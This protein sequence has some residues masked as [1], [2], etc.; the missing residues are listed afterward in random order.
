M[1]ERLGRFAI[2]YRLMIIT[3]WVALAAIITIVAPNIDDVASSDQT[4]FLPSNA[5]FIQANEVFQEAFPDEFARGS[6]FVVI[7]ASKAGGVNDPQVWQFIGELEAWLNSDAAPDNI[8]GVKAPTTNSL[9]PRL[10]VSEDQQLALVSIDLNTGHIDPLTGGT[11][12]AIDKWVGEHKLE[13]VVVEQTGASPVV[14][15]TDE[16]IRASVDHTIW[17]TVV[18]VIL[19]LLLIYR[20][21][22]SPL[23]P[24]V[25]VT[26]SYLVTIGLVSWI[27]EYV[28]TI[29]S[30]VKVLLV[31]VLYGAG[32]DY[33][34]FLI[35]RFREEMADDLGVIRA[36]HHTVA[37]VGE[38]ITS[39]AGTIFVG[40]M[41]MAF[42]EMGLFNS[43]GPALAVGIAVMLLAGLTLTPALL[44]TLGER[45]FWP[46]RAKHRATG[47]FYQKISN[48]VSVHPIATVLIIVGIMT[49][50]SIYGLT[51][52]YSYDTIKDLPEDKSAVVGFDLLGEHM[53][54]G[55]V[56]P[57]DIVV[58]E[59][60]P[61]TMAT[62][63]ARLTD[64]ISALKGIASVRGMNSPFGQGQ[65]YEN[66]LRVDTQLGFVLQSFSSIKADE[67]DIEKAVSTLNSLTDYVNL[68]AERFPEVTQDQNMKTIQ[69][70]L[71]GNPIQ[72]L[73]QQK[74]LV[75]AAAALQQRF[76]QLPNAYLMP[77]EA[78]DLF[79]ALEPISDLYLSSDGTAYRLQAVLKGLPT[80]YQAMDT[81]SEVR[82]VLKSYEGTD[83]AV[84]SGNPVMVTDIRD[85][86]DRDQIRAFG[87][88][89]AGIFL[90]LLIMLR[91]A[92]AP[93]YLLL[94][95]V[96]TFS[97]TLGI[98]ALVF[99]L[100]LGVEKLTFWM[101]F[102]TFVFLVAL[103][104]DYSIFLMG[105]V[106]EEV[107]QHGPREGVHIAVAATGG[108]ITSAGIILAGTFAAMMAGEIK[109]LSQIG[110]AVSFG[111]LIDTFV[112]RTMLVPAITTML[113][114][115]AWWPGGVPGAKTVRPVPK[116]ELGQAPQQS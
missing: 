49:P 33:C 111:V 15:D 82:E 102:F 93:I 22:V 2:R 116:D 61:Q 37:R 104:I 63:I 76:A 1:F 101:P 74:Q 51:L 89:L 60:D 58:T 24:L 4:S 12:R 80:S 32:T 53:D 46:G 34:L 59:R 95:V 38:T 78:G 21:P 56:V 81:I 31:V 41:A 40:F 105:R 44:A 62:E 18:L 7:D 96:L 64:E 47:R 36:T 57:L 69:D 91:S 90:V 3:V 48:L 11:I 85:T 50:F 9:A 77:S 67:I 39:S 92:V 103:G 28:M 70:I 16:A 29:T 73:M 30:Y 107:A 23:V 43:S 35:S 109:G 19:L 75:T 94:T 5:P 114:R 108:I 27:G 8:T 99:A 54:Q 112:V 79:A 72:I 97:T 52:Q 66:L 26:I 13:N 71:S 55:S 87:L 84:V 45:A 25:T 98:T 83:E 14:I 115:W 17:V 65:D 88:V 42:A 100:T 86:M 20:S 106:K 113:G 10:L 68:L 6:A 110:F